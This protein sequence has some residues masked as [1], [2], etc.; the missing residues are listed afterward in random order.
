METIDKCTQCFQCD[1]SHKWNKTKSYAGSDR[2]LHQEFSVT[3]MA[4]VDK[5]DGK[6]WLKIDKQS[7]FLFEIGIFRAK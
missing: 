7:N 5:V 2:R 1:C 4:L 3:Q 6:C